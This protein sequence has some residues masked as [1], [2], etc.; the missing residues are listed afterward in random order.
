MQENPCSIP[1]TTG[2]F[3]GTRS[4]TIAFDWIPKDESPETESH[5]PGPIERMDRALFLPPGSRSC[6]TGDL[7]F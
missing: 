1:A 4:A 2:K 3:A 7:F 6:T 5:Q